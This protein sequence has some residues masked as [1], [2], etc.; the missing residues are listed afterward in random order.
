MKATHNPLEQ[1][2]RH[3]RFP[4]TAD[5]ELSPGLLLRCAAHYLTAY[6]RTVGEFFDLLSDQPWPPACATGAINIAAHGKAIL[7]A[8]DS[9]EDAVTDAAIAAIRVFA[10][11]LDTDYAHGD[12]TTSAI[13]IIAAFN[14]HPDSTTAQ[15]VKALTEAADEWDR[16]HPGGAA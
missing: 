6:G 4:D 14:D 3:L 16:L 12:T 13:D 1:A 7:C 10:A 5:P 9:A 11:S 2:A 15:V 8:D